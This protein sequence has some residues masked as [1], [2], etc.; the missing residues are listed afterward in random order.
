MLSIKK[1]SIGSFGLQMDLSVGHYGC[2]QAARLVGHMADFFSDPGDRCLMS[3]H[4]S[5]A[6]L[7]H[8]THSTTSSRYKFN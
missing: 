7:H 4:V 1:C 5:D 6:I 2:Y 3:D 8:L